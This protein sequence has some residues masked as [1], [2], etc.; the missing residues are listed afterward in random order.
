MALLTAHV[1]VSVFSVQVGISNC[2]AESGNADE[3]S[4]SGAG[5]DDPG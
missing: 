2:S 5:Y 1:M 3:A 4:W